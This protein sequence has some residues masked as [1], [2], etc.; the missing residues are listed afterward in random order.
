[1][2]NAKV[3]RRVNKVI[4]K[5]NRMTRTTWSAEHVRSRRD[6]MFVSEGPGT[7]VVTRNENDSWR[8][9]YMT[10]TVCGPT[11]RAVL[12][13]L[14]KLIRSEASATSEMSRCIDP[15]R[16]DPLPEKYVIEDCKEVTKHYQGLHNYRYTGCALEYFFALEWQESNERHRT[17]EYLLSQRPNLRYAPS[18][19]ERVTANTLIQWLGSDVGQAFVCRVH[20]RMKEAIQDESVR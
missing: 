7:V 8:A 15:I 5:L 11:K 18:D 20:A 14:A 17:L 2:N 6:V 16:S 4:R 19:K 1:M 12:T 13:E 3:L 10:L 9:S